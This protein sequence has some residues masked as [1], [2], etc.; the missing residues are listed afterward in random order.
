ME[1]YKKIIKK[2]KTKLDIF[3]NI[4]INYEKSETL[5]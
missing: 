5:V 4:I 2:N 1:N 3:A